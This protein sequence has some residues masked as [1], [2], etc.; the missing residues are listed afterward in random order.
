MGQLITSYVQSRRISRVS[1]KHGLLAVL[2]VLSFSSV[3]CVSR[4]TTIVSNPPGAMTL[5]DGREIG[6]TPAS[7]DFIWYGTRQVTLIKDGFETKTDLVTIPAPWYQWPV[8]EFFADNFSPKR[9]TDR[10][11]FNF[12]LQPKQIIPDEELRARARQLRSEAQIGP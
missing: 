7:A 1:L 8:I 6:Y 3:G 12:D 2:A 11:V 10:R 9:V 5:L 4:R